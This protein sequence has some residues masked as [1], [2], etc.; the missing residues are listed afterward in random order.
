MPNPSAIPTEAVEM[1]PEPELQLL[2]ER[3]QGHTG[4]EWLIIIAGS[5]AI[6]VAVFLLAIQM[7]SV[8]PQARLQRLVIMKR[9]PLYVPRDILTQ[10]A[11]NRAK[12]TKQIN[13]ASLTSTGATPRV[14]PEPAAVPKHLEQPQQ[15]ARTLPAPKPVQPKILPEAPKLTANAEPAVNPGVPLGQ[16][17]PA[18]PPP[19]PAESGPFQ[20]IGSN[21]A[22]P[23]AHPTI[24]PPKNTLP[25]VIEGI[26]KDPATRRIIVNDDTQSRPRPGLSGATGQVQNQHAGVELQSD[27]QGADLRPYL[28]QIL[29]IVRTNWRHVMPESA[30]IGKLR[31]RTVIEFALDRNG[32]V[33]KL[34][35]GDYSGSQALDQASVA[36][37]SMSNPL[38][39][40]PADY[41]GLELRLAFTFAY[42]MATQ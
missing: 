3:P 19:T 15:A 37:L 35:I 29:S 34:V 40:L 32:R 10:R 12:V 21:T 31:G 9:I 7:S 42:N 6:H 1:R 30:I 16:L 11:P 14:R 25:A 38:P 39:P 2:L 20:N 36:G 33:V 28:A 27:P 18:P 41:K 8:V 23:V 22:P 5:A 17:P 24:A 13:L 26:A 4:K